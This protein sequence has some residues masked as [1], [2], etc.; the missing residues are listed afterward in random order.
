[1]PSSKKHGHAKSVSRSSRLELLPLVDHPLSIL[2]FLDE[3]KP[4]WIKY[5]LNKKNFDYKG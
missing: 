5:I 1:M 2:H 4:Y 3:V